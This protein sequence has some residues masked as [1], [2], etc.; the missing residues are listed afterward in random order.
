MGDWDGFD[1]LIRNADQVE[2]NALSKSANSPYAPGSGG[3][4][5]K[6]SYKSSN[7]RRPRPSELKA[8]RRGY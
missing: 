8:R 3:S 4:G 1:D 5:H 7:R 6:R 2:K